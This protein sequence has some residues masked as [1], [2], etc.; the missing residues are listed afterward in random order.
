MTQT[1][2]AKRSR[3]RDIFNIALLLVLVAAIGYLMYEAGAGAYKVII[4]VA[5][6]GVIG[7]VIAFLRKRS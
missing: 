6:V 1:T 4:V 3:G 2:P 5:I 7:A